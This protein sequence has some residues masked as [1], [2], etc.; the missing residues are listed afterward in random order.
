MSTVK[1]LIDQAQ[2]C[3]PSAKARTTYDLLAEPALLTRAKQ[4]FDKT[5]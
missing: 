4:E 5:K 1:D 3:T 2:T